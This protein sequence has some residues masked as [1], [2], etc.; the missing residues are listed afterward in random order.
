MKLKYKDSVKVTQGFYEGMSGVVID[1]HRYPGGTTYKVRLFD[2]SLY[3]GL[4]PSYV[5]VWV[6]SANL[7]KT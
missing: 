5:E 4:P 2:S 6:N 3:I 1:Q 7:E